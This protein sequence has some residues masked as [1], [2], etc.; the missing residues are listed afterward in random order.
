[1]VRY[2]AE[3]EATAVGV[4]IAAALGVAVA[5]ATAPAN[6]AGAT[7]DGTVDAAV[8][9]RMTARRTALLG[10]VGAS[11]TNPLASGDGRTL[12]RLKDLAGLLVGT[13]PAGGSAFCAPTV[14]EGSGGGIALAA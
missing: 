6:A 7:G 3:G 5:V 4:G 11:A 12:T 10:V 8:E 13:A 9:K 14:I 2:A 1:M